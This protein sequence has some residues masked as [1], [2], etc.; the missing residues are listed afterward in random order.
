MFDCAARAG[1]G[2]GSGR[3]REPALFS[4]AG[5]QKAKETCDARTNPDGCR[6]G[7]GVVCGHPDDGG[8]D[9]CMPITHK[10]I[11][12]K[13]VEVTGVLADLPKVS[14]WYSVKSKIV[15][16]ELSIG[17]D[18]LTAIPIKDKTINLL[19]KAAVFL[20][21]LAAQRYKKIYVR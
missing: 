6:G 5:P 1:Q 16:T 3:D 10:P 20:L 12:E 4:L 18:F 9:G 19:V 7:D 8:S 15:N 17:T 11:L 21:K 13:K 2:P 14:F